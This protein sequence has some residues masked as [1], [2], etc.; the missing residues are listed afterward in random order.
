VWE[1]K[2]LEKLTSSHLELATEYK[3]QLPSLTSHVH[4]AHL[5]YMLRPSLNSLDFLFETLDLLD[6]EVRE[7]ILGFSFFSLLNP[8]FKAAETGNEKLSDLMIDVVDYATFRKRCYELASQGI[9]D[10]FLVHAIVSETLAWAWDFGDPSKVDEVIRRHRGFISFCE[11]ALLTEKNEQRRSSLEGMIGRSR[12]G[13]ASA[14]DNRKRWASHYKTFC[15]VV[16]SRLTL[17]DPLRP[18]KTP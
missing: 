7:Q 11:K 9:G 2:D 17:E 3:L 6:G 14:P 5:Q 4:P 13:I 12:E 1:R 16:L 15:E 8:R 10:D 18:F